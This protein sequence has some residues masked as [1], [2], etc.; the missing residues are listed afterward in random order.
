MGRQNSQL[1]LRRNEIGFH[2]RAR[3]MIKNQIFKFR[4]NCPAPAESVRGVQGAKKQGFVAPYLV[5]L[6]MTATRSNAPE[7]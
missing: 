7:R 6:S 2:V 3:M 4:E 1:S 5:T